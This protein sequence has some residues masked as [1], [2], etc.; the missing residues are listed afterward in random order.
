MDCFSQI[1]FEVTQAHD[2]RS[3]FYRS[4]SGE[5]ICGL[6]SAFCGKDVPYKQIEGV[7]NSCEDIKLIFRSATICFIKCESDAV[8]VKRAGEIEAL[9]NGINGREHVLGVLVCL[10]GNMNYPYRIEGGGL[11]PFINTEELD[12]K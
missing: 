4:Q 8:A 11:K 6:V 7:H 1:K 3:G 2:G 5:I 10:S 9:M 12:Q